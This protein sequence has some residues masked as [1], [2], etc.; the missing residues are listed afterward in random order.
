NILSNFAKNNLDRINEVKKN[1]QHYNFPP[2]IKSRKLLKSRTLKYLD[3]IPSIIKGKIASKYYNLAYQQQKTS[4]NSKMSKD[5]HWQISWNKY[6][7]G[8]YGL[9]RQHFINLVILSKWRNLINSKEL[10][11]PTLRYWTTNDFSAYV[12]ANEIIIRLVMEDMHCSQSKAEDIINKTTEYGTIVMDSI[13]LEH[14]L[15]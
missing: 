13:P 11:N 9:E 4:S 5:E 14:D 6:V 7:G 15:G 1:Y 2:P 12:L 3:L 8:Y 10:S